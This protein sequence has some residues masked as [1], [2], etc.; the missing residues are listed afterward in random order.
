MLW[1]DTLYCFKNVHGNTLCII[2]QSLRISL[3]FVHIA[4]E[5]WG[6]SN[7]EL[8]NSETSVVFSFIDDY[9]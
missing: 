1:E 5:I 7:N 4:K 9:C 3:T 6:F 8:K 2:F